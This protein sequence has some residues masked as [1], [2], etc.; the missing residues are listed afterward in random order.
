[1]NGLDIRPGMRFAS[2]QTY[3]WEVAELVTEGVSLPHARLRAVYD[4]EVTRLVACAVL[5]NPARFK[6]LTH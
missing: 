4:P 3:E 5:A 2:H 6:P 1:M